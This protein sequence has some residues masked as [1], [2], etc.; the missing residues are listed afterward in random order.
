MD[1]VLRERIKTLSLD[2]CWR[3][4]GFER[5]GSLDKLGLQNFSLEIFLKR[6]SSIALKGEGDQC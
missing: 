5:R 6:F 2:Y 3:L 4:R 1:V